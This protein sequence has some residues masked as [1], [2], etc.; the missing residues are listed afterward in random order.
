MT[1]TQIPWSDVELIAAVEAYRRMQWLYSA[2]LKPVKARFFDL[3]HNG[4]L[5][6]RTKGAFENRMMNITYIL[7]SHPIRND[8]PSLS[9][10]GYRPLRNVGEKVEP[11]LYKLLKETAEKQY[12]AL[13][14]CDRLKINR[15]FVAGMNQKGS[16]IDRTFFQEVC[17]HL[18]LLSSQG[19]QESVKTVLKDAQIPYKPK[20]CFSAGSTVQAHGIRLLHAALEKYESFPYIS[21]SDTGLGTAQSL[22]TLVSI[23]NQNKQSYKRKANRE[24]MVNRDESS[25]VRRYC[26]FLKGKDAEITIVRNKI[27]PK[28][29]SAYLYSDI[30]IEDRHHLIEAK[31]ATDRELIRYAIG[32]LIDYGRYLKKE[33]ISIQGR[34][35]LLPER[36]NEDLM[37]LIEEA[38]LA[39]IWEDNS[40][41]GLFH[42][43]EDGRFC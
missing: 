18:N 37:E 8:E 17:R 24:T 23:E 26:N 5:A 19:K 15:A 29:S 39:C 36:P 1:P 9:E 21:Q 40:I 32:Q 12:P 3:Y 2:G 7:E 33:N 20:E 22:V 38:K 11:R 35:I 10:H 6:N 43:N 31:S 14:I 34:G 16:T 4:A 13:L 28:D 41:V 25:L 42:D 27:R 30:W